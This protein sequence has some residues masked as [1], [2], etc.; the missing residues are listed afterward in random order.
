MKAILLAALQIFLLLLKAH[1]S[2]NDESQEYREHLAKAQEEL[3]KIAV[4]FE[5]K[6]RFSNIHP[7]EVEN[8]QK[9]LD[10]EE[11]K[12]GMHSKPQDGH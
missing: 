8:L 9:Q 7:Q 10:A 2:R 4:Q 5:Q 11:G 12:H 6:L 1:F 3:D